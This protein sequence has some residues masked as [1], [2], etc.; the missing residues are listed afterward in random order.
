MKIAK[1]NAV[2]FGMVLPAFFYFLAF[3]SLAHAQ[4][5]FQP[6]A[7]PGSMIDFAGDNAGNLCYYDAADKSI[8][9]YG[10]QYLIPRTLL[11]ESELPASMFLYYPNRTI[12][13]KV[14]FACDF[15]SNSTW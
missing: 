1:K 13:A 6:L 3:A 7:I 14:E 12:G 15:S 8:K 11:R 9:L 10:D 2:R 5:V 4:V